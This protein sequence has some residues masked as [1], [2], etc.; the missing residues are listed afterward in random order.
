MEYIIYDIVYD[1]RISRGPKDK[2]IRVGDPYAHAVVAASST[3]RAQSL[4][5]EHLKKDEKLAEDF[6]NAPI[7]VRD[8]CDT[9][10]KTDKEGVITTQRRILEVMLATG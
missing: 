9:K 8:F 3:E 5:E 6:R 4:L 7:K 10:F 1:A 2:P